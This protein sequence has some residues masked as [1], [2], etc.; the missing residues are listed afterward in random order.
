MSWELRSQASPGLWCSQF[1]RILEL[2]T[3]QI[4]VTERH[5]KALSL[6]RGPEMTLPRVLASFNCDY[7]VGKFQIAMPRLARCHRLIFMNAAFTSCRGKI[8]RL[9]WCDK[10]AGHVRV[11]HSE[12]DEEESLNR[13]VSDHA[14][15]KGPESAH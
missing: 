1:E 14:G 7:L 6:L 10:C 13:K 12:N 15:R 2:S 3:D 8:A 9:P 5:M 4:K 11:W